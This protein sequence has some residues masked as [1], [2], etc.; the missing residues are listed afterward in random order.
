M[1]FGLCYVEGCVRN[2]KDPLGSAGVSLTLRLGERLAR[3]GAD[4]TYRRGPG[5][6][7]LNRSRSC[8]C[9]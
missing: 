6:L 2:A 4:R 3:H 9:I 7:F 8:R 5:A 1:E